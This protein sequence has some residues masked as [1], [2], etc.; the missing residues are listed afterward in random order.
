VT[1]RHCRLRAAARSAIPVISTTG[2]VNMVKIT[3]LLALLLVATDA[4]AQYQNRTSTPFL[5]PASE[6]G[7][8]SPR[9]NKKR[10][11]EA[12]L[13]RFVLRTDL[14]G[15]FEFPKQVDDLLLLGVYLFRHVG[16]PLHFHVVVSGRSTTV[17]EQ[18]L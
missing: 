16:P 10:H 13:F 3:V 9:P 2:Q 17:P 7:V 8:I 5:R 6:V 18:I 11:R 4:S 14:F 12:T 15:G 1:F